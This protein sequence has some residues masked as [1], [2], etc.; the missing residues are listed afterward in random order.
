MAKWEYAAIVKDGTKKVA[1]NATTTCWKLVQPR[2][3]P[4]IITSMYDSKGKKK[5]ET[6]RLFSAW[7]TPSVFKDLFEGVE[8]G[9]ENQPPI[10]GIKNTFH[11]NDSAPVI[12]FE[13]TDLLVL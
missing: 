4:H 9:N 7:Q 6:V 3:E 12:L 8:R 10:K 13:A 1:T 2:N 5:K 11:I